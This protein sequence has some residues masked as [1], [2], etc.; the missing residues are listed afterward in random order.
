MATIMSASLVMDRKST[1]WKKEWFHKQPAI[2]AVLCGNDDICYATL[3]AIDAMGM[4]IPYDIG[5]ITF[6]EVRWFGFQKCPIA[7][8]C[9]PTADIGTVAV[10]L[11]I[12]RSEGKFRDDY[13]DILLDAELI[14]RKSCMK[15]GDKVSQD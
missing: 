2:D 14:V 15:G 3:G 5:V 8:I 11:L 12:N 9:Q 13:K 6:D 7:A 1:P 4:E 10:D